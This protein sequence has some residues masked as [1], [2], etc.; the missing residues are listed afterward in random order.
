MKL[1]AA[2]INEFFGFKP[3]EDFFVSDIDNVCL[4]NTIAVIS[5]QPI[6][7]E[8]PRYIY[9]H[10]LTTYYKMLHAYVCKHHDPN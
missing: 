6:T 8:I 9:R 7:D 4:T 5:G 10:Q 3:V 1:N 2:I